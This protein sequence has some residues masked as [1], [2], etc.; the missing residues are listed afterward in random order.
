MNR[1]LLARHGLRP[2]QVVTVGDRPAD[3]DAG[4]ALGALGVLL[5][6]PGI[7]LDAGDSPRIT[8]L[9]ELLDLIAD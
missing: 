7:P 9:R 4:R 5:V 3:V 6:T 2:S 1:E 8:D